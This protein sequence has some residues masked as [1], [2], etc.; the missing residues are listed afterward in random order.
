MS[1]LNVDQI[2]QIAIMFQT[3]ERVRE[4]L[5]QAKPKAKAMELLLELEERLTI[6][7]HKEEVRKAMD[8][9]TSL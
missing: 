1:Q 4:E 6:E 9:V 7:T 2:R 3:N 5:S 8:S